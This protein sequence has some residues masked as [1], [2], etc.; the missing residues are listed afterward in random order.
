MATGESRISNGYGEKEQSTQRKMV[1]TSNN[2]NGKQTYWCRQAWQWNFNTSY[3]KKTC[4]FRLWRTILLVF[5]TYTYMTF[6]SDKSSILGH[7]NNDHNVKLTNIIPSPLFSFECFCS[8][9]IHFYFQTE[10]VSLRLTAC[11]HIPVAEVGG[12]VVLGGTVVVGGPVVVGGAVV[13]GVT[14]VD[15]VRDK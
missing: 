12:W 8:R 11:A 3:R 6:N 15:K 4:T 7:G 10:S 9:E 5:Q 13:V 14:A 2:T 1:S